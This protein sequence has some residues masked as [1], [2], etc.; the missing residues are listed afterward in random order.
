MAKLLYSALTPKGVRTEGFVDAGSA[1][2]AR[3]VLQARGLGQIELH[4]G[5]STGHDIDLDKLSPGEQAALARVQLELARSPTLGNAIRGNLMAGRWWLTCMG[6]VLAVAAWHGAWGWAALALVLLLAPVV[7]TLWAWRSVG[8]YL[9]M[10]RA[11]SIGRWDTASTLIRQLEPAAVDQPQTGFDLAVRAAQIALRRR[12]LDDVLR[13]LEPWREKVAAWPGQ[14]ESRTS[15]LYFYAEDLDGC[16]RVMKRA[17]EENPDDPS[18]QV[19]HALVLARAGRSDEAEVAFA[20]I[21]RTLL[22]P[23]G[24]GFVAWIRGRIQLE[25]GEPAAAAT[26]KQ[27]VASL[28]ALKDQ[29][30]VWTALAAASGDYAI[31]LHQQGRSDEARRQLERVWPILTAHAQPSFLNLVEREGLRPA[32]PN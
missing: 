13:D 22:P 32:G 8:R 31:A 24:Q 10:I 23:H 30:A 15:T 21:D 18:I 2:E 11:F 14:F 27:A 28:L 25:R 7:M 17:L 12:P 19:D 29:P 3:R 1:D 16:T 26:L 9:A 6:A 5:T 20:R 4:G